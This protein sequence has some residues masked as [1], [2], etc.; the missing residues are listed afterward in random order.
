MEMNIGL[1]LKRIMEMNIGLKLKR[2]HKYETL[3]KNLRPNLKHDINYVS[4]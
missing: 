1:K 2:F 3:I 4:F